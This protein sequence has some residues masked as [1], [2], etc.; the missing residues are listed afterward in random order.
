MTLKLDLT[1]AWLSHSI[2]KTTCFGGRPFLHLQVKKGER[3]S[4]ALNAANPA[5]FQTSA[6]V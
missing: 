4:G 1:I 3:Q 6:S 2:L 5:R